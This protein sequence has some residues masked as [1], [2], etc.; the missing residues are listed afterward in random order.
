MNWKLT[1]AVTLTKSSAYAYHWYDC[2]NV[3]Q[4]NYV[5]TAGTDVPPGGATVYVCGF[6]ADN[7]GNVWT[8]TNNGLCPTPTP[9]PTPAPCRTYQLSGGIPF[10][11][12]IGWYDCSNVYHT[13]FVLPAG[14]TIC[15]QQGSITLLYG[16]GYWTDIG[17][18]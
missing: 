10:E 1:N 2:N 3:Y 7:G 12:E 15:A 11:Y 5:F 9:T 4:T 14:G 6:S 13:M 18:C 17:P 16:S 8:V